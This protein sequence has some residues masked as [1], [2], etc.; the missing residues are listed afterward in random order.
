MI[1][2]A[3]HNVMLLTITSSKHASIACEILYFTKFMKVTWNRYKIIF[4]A[5]W[6][7]IILLILYSEWWGFIHPLRFPYHNLGIYFLSLYDIIYKKASRSKVINLIILLISNMRQLLLLRESLRIERRWIFQAS[8]PNY[9][10]C[11]IS[12]DLSECV[13]DKKRLW[14]MCCYTTSK[15]C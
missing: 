7:S 15:I 12:Y 2:V 4:V 10:C 3:H 1:V 8:W 9:C 5:I 11:N 14:E 13:I 6:T